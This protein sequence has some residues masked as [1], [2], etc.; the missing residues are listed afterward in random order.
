MPKLDSL[1]ILFENK[2]F[3]VFTVSESLLKPS[4]LDNKIHLPGYSCVRSDRLG[5]VGGGCLANVRDEIPYRPRPDLGTSSTESCV[6]EISRPKCKKLLIWAI[7]RASDLNMASFIQDLDTSLS[8]LPEN[9]ELILLG[10]FNVNLTGSNLNIDKAMKRK[11]IQ[12]TN[13]HELD[14][15]INK[16]TR[17]T[18]RS[19][20]LIDLLFSNTTYRVTDHR[21]I[22]LTISDHSMIFCVVKSDVTKAPGKT[23]EYRSFKNYYICGYKP[24]YVLVR[25]H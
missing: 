11:L 10:D 15:L 14:Q 23:I 16:P 3:D 19:S 12:V 17:I 4:I 9:I 25:A 8:A 6:V 18:E 20:T 22:H 7:Y 1:K 2:P 21:V 13:S 5:K 24:N